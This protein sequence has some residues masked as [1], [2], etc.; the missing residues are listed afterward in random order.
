MTYFYTSVPGVFPVPDPTSGPTIVTSPR[1]EVEESL[2]VS[3]VPA[4]R[5]DLPNG[6][7]VFRTTSEHIQR[8]QSD[9]RGYFI[10]LATKLYWTTTNPIPSQLDQLL[11]TEWRLLV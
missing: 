2:T 8:L 6:T 7:R 1:L 5:V 10:R 3:R 9:E 4:E 11:T